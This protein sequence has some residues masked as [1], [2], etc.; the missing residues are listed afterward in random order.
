MATQQG[1]DGSQNPFGDGKGGTGMAQGKGNNFVTNPQ[2]AGP[3]ASKPQPLVGVNGPDQKRGPNADINP[4]SVPEGGT[5]VLDK[6]TPKDR[7]GNP[8]GAG[9][10]AD[11]RKPFKLSGGG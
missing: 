8:I 6:V 3:Q 1:G 5:N 2:G 9:S 4:Q 11:G 7:P 10:L